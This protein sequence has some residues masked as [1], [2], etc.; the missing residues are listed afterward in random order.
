MLDFK[1]RAV[2]ITGGGSGIGKA[3][4][5]LFAKKGAWV[6]ILEW[7]EEHAKQT[8]KEIEDAGGKVI[9]HICD[10]SDQQQVAA[11]FKKVEAIDIL[12]NSAGISHIGQADTTS[13]QDFERIFNVNVKGVYNCLHEAIPLMKANKKGVILNVCSV[14]AF[15]ALQT[16]LP[17]Q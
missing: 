6:H 1:D 13:V 3:T 12:V 2:V 16:G 14:A 15:M 11:T 4:S 9:V 8:M 10:V 17:I 7:N 5:L